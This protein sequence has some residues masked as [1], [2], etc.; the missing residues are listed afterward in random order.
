MLVSCRAVDRVQ[1][2]ERLLREAEQREKA[3]THSLTLYERQTNHAKEQTSRT[4][5]RMACVAENARDDVDRLKT[6]ATKDSRH[7]HR[8]LRRAAVALDEIAALVELVHSNNPKV[9]PSDW[10]HLLRRQLSSAARGVLGAEDHVVHLLRHLGDADFVNPAPIAP[11]F[12]TDSDSD[13][14]HDTEIDTT[15]RTAR[16]RQ[17]SRWS[18]SR[19]PSTA[20]GPPD[21]EGRQ[22]ET[23]SSFRSR[24][25]SRSRSTSPP[26]AVQA[27]SERYLSL[28]SQHRH[29]QAELWRLREEH[30]TVEKAEGLARAMDQLAKESQTQVQEA[31]REVT[32]IQREV[33]KG[34]AE[35]GRLRERLE[36]ALRGAHEVEKRLLVAEGTWDT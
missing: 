23:G 1:T 29:L 6:V 15:R 26:G 16:T 13:R 14:D 10:P 32:K 21:A 19:R 5:R 18:S 7:S 3:A 8:A 30:V 12:D 22:E 33:E 20:S 27:L 2:L 25:R 4:N 28:E 34:E 36:V 11:R 31:R 17:Q 24:S 35:Q 9:L